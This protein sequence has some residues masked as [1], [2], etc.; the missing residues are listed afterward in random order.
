MTSGTALNGL[1]VNRDG[2][3]RGSCPDQKNAIGGRLVAIAGIDHLEGRQLC[4]PKQS[5]AS[6]EQ[7]PDPA[8]SLAD[9]THP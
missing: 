7:W 2:L 4:N 1:A 9:D 3:L 5:T 6:L 8:S